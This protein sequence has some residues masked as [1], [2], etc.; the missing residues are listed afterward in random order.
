MVFYGCDNPNFESYVATKGFVK[1]HGSFTYIVFVA[2]ELKTDAVN[3]SSGYY[4]AHHL[5]EYIDCA[6]LDRTI[7][8]VIEMIAD[9]AREDFP[10]CEF[11]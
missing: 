9:A 6:E 7:E 4:N 8:R 5:D 3:L 10:R 11:A 1:S 2:P